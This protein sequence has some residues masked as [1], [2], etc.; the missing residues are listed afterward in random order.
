MR[1]ILITL[2]IAG[3]TAF[4][5]ARGGHAN[6]AYA[7]RAPSGRGNAPA[8]TWAGRSS[9]GRTAII[10]YP[11]FYGGYYLTPPGYGYG[12]DPTAS[13]Y[14]D[15]SQGY[16]GDPGYAYGSGYG[17]G[18]GYGNPSQSPAVMVNP[19]YR[20]DPVN[21]VLHD[22]SNTPLP[23]PTFKKYESPTH[24]YD[25]QAAADQQPTIYL[26]AMKDHTI[27]PAVAYWVEGDTLNYVTTEGSL[28]R[29]TLDL[30][31]RDFSAQLNQERHVEFKLPAQK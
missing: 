2:L 31:D 7:G 26:I 20:P 27:F 21:P 19:G 28:N 15:P 17:Y 24:P 14:A 18:P 5:Q 23:E 11:V 3:C 6:G 1:P 29:A 25:N 13:G 10:P 4:A 9:Y 30:V 16:Y 22:Y 8:H 12:Y